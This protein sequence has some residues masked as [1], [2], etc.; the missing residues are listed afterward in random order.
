MHRWVWRTALGEI[1]DGL[2]VCH[3]C[4]NR[5]C[6]RLDHLF[7]GT[8]L[9]NYL[10]AVGKG[11][12]TT[13]VGVPGRRG[14]P[15]ATAKLTPDDVLAIRASNQGEMKLARQYGVTQLTIR[16]ARTGETWS[17]LPKAAE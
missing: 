9:D 11:R 13:P 14:G 3:H 10:D 7:L 5:L 16:R 8:A 4:D 2:F 17:N 6:Y 1:P 12:M 15:P